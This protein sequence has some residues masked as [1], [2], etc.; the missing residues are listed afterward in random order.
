MEIKNIFC[1]GRNYKDHALE[2]GNDVPDT[3]MVFSKPTHAL[4]KGD[5][6]VISYPNDQGDIHHELELVLYIGNDVEEGFKV[7]DVVTNMALGIDFTLRDVQSVQKKKGHPWLIAK[8]FKNSAVITD[9]W[10]F[11]G[12]ETCKETDF[13]LLC[14][15]ETVQHGNIQS[16]IFDF[17]TILEYIHE[18]FGL[19]KGDIIYTGT[20]EGVQAITDKD[21]YV[22]KWGNE[23][24]GSFTVSKI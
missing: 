9:F 3:P 14:N 7:D 23:V 6:S 2:L 5:G 15:E 12:V 17:Q 4:V 19:G 1:I 18:K 11:P 22:L 10:D 8:G 24:K 21:E 20:P 13:S 16:V